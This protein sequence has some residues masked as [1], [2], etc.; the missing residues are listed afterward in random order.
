M[1]NPELAAFAELVR[2]TDYMRSRVEVV[3]LARI[4]AAI[5]LKEAARAKEDALARVAANREQIEEFKQTQSR[6]SAAREELEARIQALEAL[7][8][9]SAAAAAGTAE[10]RDRLAEQLAAVEAERVE[11]AIKLEEA[12]APRRTRSPASPP[13]GSR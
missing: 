1:A 2:S 11:A 4:E 9:E 6:T 5:K 7:R 3:E 13:I 8:A 12:A 10:E